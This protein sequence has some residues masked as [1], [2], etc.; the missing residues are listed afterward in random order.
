[1]LLNPS[2]Y[3][4]PQGFTQFAG[5][6]IAGPN[7]GIFGQ[8]GVYGGNSQFGYPP[9][10]SGLGQPPQPS[11]QPLGGPFTA[12]PLL[13]AYWQNPAW[14]SPFASMPFYGNSLAG[15]AEAHNPLTQILP[16]LVQLAQQISVHGTV[17]QQIGM[18]LQQLTQQL[19]I[20]SPHLQQAAF[21]AAQSF[22]QNPFTSTPAGAYAGFNP[23]AAQAWGATRPQTVQ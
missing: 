21:S 19:A 1:M 11:Q 22:G 16:V 6:P 8:A 4:L 7:P 14:Q 13:S 10:M 2:S 18:V 17:A 23:Q 15:H 12:S 9:A 5:A 20:A 3:F